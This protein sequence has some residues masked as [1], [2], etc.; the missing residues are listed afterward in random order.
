MNQRIWTVLLPLLAATPLPAHAAHDWSLRE[1][2][3]LGFVASWEG[4]EFEGVFHHFDAAVAFDPADLAGSHFEV[5][6]DVTSTDTQSSDRDEGLAD[7]EWF[8]FAHYPQAT[9]VTSS[10]GALSDGRYEAKGTLTI[11]G[12]SREVSFPFTWRE[13]DGT[14]K[15]Q[16][17]T[18]LQRTD[19]HIGEGE[20]AEDDSIGM[21]VR[22]LADLT[23]GMKPDVH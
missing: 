8:D 7:P 21:S 3:K 4:S 6:V 9:F 1:G 14:A 23:F 2:G 18:V 15:L 22:V 10:I 5:K 16:G 12:V 13:Q 17:E 20:W 11:K 19:F